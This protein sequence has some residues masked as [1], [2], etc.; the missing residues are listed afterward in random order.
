MFVFLNS[1]NLLL[2]AVFK[3]HLKKNLISA[4][5]NKVPIS[6]PSR[7]DNLLDANFFDV[8]PLSEPVDVIVCCGQTFM[9][10]WNV[11]DG[12]N[13][14]QLFKR[15]LRKGG[16][17]II[18]DIPG[19]LWPEVANGGWSNGVNEEETL[20]LVWAKNDAVFTIRE[21]EQ[22]DAESWELKK[23]DRNVSVFFPRVRVDKKNRIQNLS[24]AWNPRVRV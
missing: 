11:D 6:L 4:F 23:N 2:A 12:V 19:D 17:I 21:G 7:I 10:L 5:G 13:A 20:Q 3:E 18:D 24:G 16:M 15:S 9:L 14:L 8:L 22:V 1:L